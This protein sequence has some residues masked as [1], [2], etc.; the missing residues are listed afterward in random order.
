MER[1]TRFEHNRWLG[2]KRTQVVY[3]VDDLDDPSIIDE[4]MA[5]ETFLAFGPDTLA[6]A[7]NRGYHAYK[8]TARAEA[9][10]TRRRRWSGCSS[11][12]R[13]DRHLGPPGPAPQRSRHLDARVWSSA[14][15]SP[16]D[17]AAVGC[18]PSRSPSWPTASPPSSAGRC[19]SSASGAAAT[20]RATSRWAGWL[21]DLIGGQ[22]L[23]ARRRRRRRRVDG[24]VRHRGRADACARRPDDPGSAAWPRWARPADF[25]DWASHPRRLLLHARDVGHHPLA[26]VPA[27]TSTRGR[28]SCARSGPWPRRRDLGSPAAARAARL[29]RRVGAGVRRPGAGRRPRRGR[30]PHHRGGQP[31]A[32]PRPAGGRHPARLARPPA[33]PHAAKPTR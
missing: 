23:P 16:T 2:D 14:T 5:A 17:A 28:A 6:E 4:L 19:W 26:V 10:P 32:A 13:R 7:R 15:G 27:S 9:R 1:P 18:R 24:R 8:G 12:Q 21:D 25:D 11:R 30:S 22:R 29:R 31:P 33:Q 3:D 20:P